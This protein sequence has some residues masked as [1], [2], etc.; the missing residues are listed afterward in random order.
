[1]DAIRRAN[2]KLNAIADRYPGESIVLG[3]PG[4]ADIVSRGDLVAYGIWTRR[5]H[6]ACAC[7]GI[8]VADALYAIANE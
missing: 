4:M 1:M 3:L 6:D 5:L 2:R 7:A 8:D